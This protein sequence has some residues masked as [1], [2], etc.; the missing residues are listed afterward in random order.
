MEKDEIK[1]AQK[2]ID[3]ELGQIVSSVPKEL[4]SLKKAL[5]CS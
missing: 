1:E 4:Q 2:L 3:D 5:F